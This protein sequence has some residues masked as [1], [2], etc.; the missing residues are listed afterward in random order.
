MNDKK[1]GRPGKDGHSDNNSLGSEGSEQATNHEKKQARSWREQIKIHP[2]A[3]MFPFLTVSELKELA[4]D[5]EKH[6]LRTPVTIMRDYW[7]REDGTIN[8]NDYDL[9]LLDGRSR[10]D[11][12]ESL[13]WEIKVDPKKARGNQ[14]RC[15][16]ADGE[17]C[18]EIWAWASDDADEDPLAYIV[19]QNI[20]RRHLGT[21]DKR[22]VIAALLRADPAKSN[23][24]VAGTAKVDDK[25]VASVRQ[26]LESR[27]EIPN[28]TAT[29]DSKG[30]AQ[31]IRKPRK[32]KAAAPR[33][34]SDIITAPR[35]EPP[36][37]Q[38]D[39]NRR[40]AERGAALILKRSAVTAECVTADYFQLAPEEQRRVIDQIIVAGHALTVAQVALVPTIAD[41]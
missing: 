40:A 10:L 12:I 30:R 16:R 26:D 35:G 13:G 2:A 11:A 7:P 32:A 1:N 21:E 19:S 31:P 29:T 39:A 27:S 38:I 41:E 24:A 18:D 8:A 14:I 6:G 5:I 20:L 15:F 9:M 25:T 36:A 4:A 17:E 22:D 37:V 33:P 34:S 28:V 3:D 23:R